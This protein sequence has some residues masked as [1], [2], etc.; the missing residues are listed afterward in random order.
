MGPF[1]KSKGVFCKSLSVIFFQHRWKPLKAYKMFRD[2]NKVKVSTFLGCT[3]K[4]MH[5]H[6]KPIIRK[7]PE[8]LIV[9]VSTNSLRDS[10]NPT[11]C[12]EGIIDLTRWIKSA[13]PE[14]EVVLSS[15]TAHPNDDQLANHVKEGNSTLRNFCHQNQW[16]L[17]DHSNITVDQ[18]LNRSGHHLNETGTSQL[19][20]NFLEVIKH[21]E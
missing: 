15:L 5:E 1:Q 21:K 3:T 7:N 2:N 18:H 13:A 11:A 20:H 6:I 10:E 9:H 12:V 4:D 8:H 17:I 14:S 16:K 19:P